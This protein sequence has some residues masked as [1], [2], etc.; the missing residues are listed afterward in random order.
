MSK[1]ACPRC[2]PT[3]KLEPDLSCL[4]PLLSFRPFVCLSRGLSLNLKPTELEM[5]AR[6]A[7]NESPEFLYLDLTSARV[8]GTH[9]HTQLLAV[10]AEELN[11]V[12]HTRRQTPY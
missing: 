1:Q 2:V 11:S 7:D 4:R 12:P 6:L 5:L 9:C 8:T 10:G 3:R